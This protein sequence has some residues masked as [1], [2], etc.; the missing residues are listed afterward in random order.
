MTS[1]SIRGDFPVG[2]QL[3]VTANTRLREAPSVTSTVRRVIPDG[4]IVLSA[5]AKPSAWWYGITW[6]GQSDLPDP[7]LTTSQLVDA[8]GWLA[9][10]G[11]P[12]WGF[13]VMNS[14]HHNDPLA[15]TGGFAIDF[16]ANDAADD[17][18]FVALVNEDPYFVEIGL[19]GDYGAHRSAITS[20]GKCSFIESAATHVHASV[21][22]AFCG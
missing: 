11:A 18:R 5:V 20:S 14:G 15:H 2:T 13:S 1:S 4:S 21:R 8:I 17:A 10:H 12:D 9:T 3:E 22:R 19:A 6:Q 16:F 7:G